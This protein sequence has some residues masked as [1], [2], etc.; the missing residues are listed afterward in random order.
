MQWDLLD[1]FLIQLERKQKMNDE[2]TTFCIID[3]EDEILFTKKK[4]MTK[5]EREFVLQDKSDEL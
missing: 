3:E 5:E 4:M 1:L 2:D